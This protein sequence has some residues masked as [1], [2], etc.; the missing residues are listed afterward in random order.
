M[1]ESRHTELINIHSMGKKYSHGVNRRKYMVNNNF[2]FTVSSNTNIFTISAK[3]TN[4][5]ELM[6]CYE[7]NNSASDEVPLKLEIFDNGTLV[8]NGSCNTSVSRSFYES[9]RKNLGI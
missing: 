5:I 9:L 4:N 6:N 3:L 1:L 2:S 7:D 8:Q